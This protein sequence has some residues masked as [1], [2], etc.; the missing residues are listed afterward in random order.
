MKKIKVHLFSILIAVGVGALA[1]F[2]TRNSVETFRSLSKPAL[3][4]PAEVFPFVWTVLYVI[5]GISA[6]LIYLSDS[7]RKKHALTLYGIQLAAN[8]LWTLFFFCLRAYWLS[9]FWLLFLLC[10]IAAMIVVYRK[11]S[12]PAALL[13]LP[14]LLWVLFAGYLNFMIAV[15][16]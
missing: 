8:F 9:F 15:L 10:L 12:R 6:A 1:G 11:I 16:N 13:Q 3:T 4:P 7:P 5:M 14:Y 2:L